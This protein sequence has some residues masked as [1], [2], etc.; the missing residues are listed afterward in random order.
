MR[1]IQQFRGRLLADINQEQSEA[2]I[3]EFSENVFTELAT[4]WLSETGLTENPEVCH[5]ERSIGNRIARVNGFAVSDDEAT[6]DLFTT[7]FNGQGDTAS[8]AP[9]DFRKAARQALAFFRSVSA[10]MVASLEPSS[11]E[12]GMARRIADLAAGLHRVRIFVLSDGVCSLKAIDEEETD[13]P[14][15]LY[16]LIDIERM[17]R[18]VQSGL[19]RDEIF[20]DFREFDGDGLRCLHAPEISE[21]Y[22]AYL[23]LV[24]GEILFHLYDRYG[25]RLLEKNVRS[26]LS[27]RGKV[28]RGI[29]DTLRKEPDRFLA[30]NNG[31]VATVDEIEIVHNREA[32]SRHV[33][34]VRGL[35]IVNGGQTTASLHRARRD[36]K[37]DLSSVYVPAKI[38]LIDPGKIDEVVPKISLYANSQNNIQMADFSAND[39]YH[40]ELSKLSSNVWCPGEQGRWFYERTRGEYEVEKSR[41]ARTPAQV[42]KFNERTPR[43]RKFD[44]VELAKFILSW[45]QRPDKVSLGGQKCF[46]WFMQDLKDTHSKNWLPDEE[47]FKRTIAKALLYKE[48]MSVVRKEKFPAYRA[49]VVTYVVAYLSH[50]TGRQVDL[51]MIW[52]KQKLSEDLVELLRDLAYVVR[53]TIVE[54][55]GDRN[56]TEWC[57]KAECW[58]AVRACG[59]KLPDQ[60]PGEVRGTQAG[61]GGKTPSSNLSPA[62]LNAMERCQ[63]VSAQ[64]WIEISR[65][66][67]STGKLKDWQSGIAA[68]LGGY[69]AR[70][71][72]KPPSV[73]QAHRG[74]EIIRLAEDEGGPLSGE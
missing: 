2:G 49:Q 24:P 68:T 69:A 22:D 33:V 59:F 15:V 10:E 38:S 47:Y 51:D 6:L 60:L 23:A 50:R 30:Y 41:T 14:K 71:W 8:F 17:H 29:R 62:D 66:G 13:R 27:A 61:G 44:K 39:P 40:V 16:E 4:E 12:Y 20:V 42:R 34:S 73:K 3:P 45:E 70:D 11:A 56:V 53:D 35:Q 54:S 19:P 72:T 36:D 55:A 28:N 31:I 25:P 64:D 46:S 9:E 18:L 48:A 63:A 26:F 57:K 5:F 1:E 21:D 52:Q 7:C 32:G 37:V 65:W 74:V 67:N 58:T 43:S